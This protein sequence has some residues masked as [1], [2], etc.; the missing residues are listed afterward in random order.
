MVAG[1]IGGEDI[2]MRYR[3][4]DFSIEQTSTGKFKWVVGANVDTGLKQSRSGTADTWND[5]LPAAE[6]A[7]DQILLDKNSN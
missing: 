1:R 3:Q 7:I 4:I 2:T 6:H 5:A